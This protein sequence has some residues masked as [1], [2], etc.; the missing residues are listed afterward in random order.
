[1]T[2][3]LNYTFS[4]EAL[5]VYFDVVE[6]HQGCVDKLNPAL[7]LIGP[8]TSKNKYSVPI[9]ILMFS[10]TRYLFIVAAKQF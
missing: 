7:T 10:C 1:M 5:N 8:T 9:F 4:Y 6:I 2:K 3:E